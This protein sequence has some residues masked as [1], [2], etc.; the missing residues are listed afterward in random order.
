MNTQVNC[1]WFIPVTGYRQKNDHCKQNY[2]QQ[3]EPSPTPRCTRELPYY[4]GNLGATV[5][6]RKKIA[7]DNHLVLLMEGYLEK[8]PTAP[9]MPEP[10]GLADD[11]DCKNAHN[12]RLIRSTD[13]AK[14]KHTNYVEWMEAVRNECAIAEADWLL[15]QEKSPPMGTEDKYVRKLTSAI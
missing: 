12:L 9:Q 6:S 2:K 15:K 1:D 10:I 7:D 8:T 11:M 14:V 5:G 3:T 13:I 4:S